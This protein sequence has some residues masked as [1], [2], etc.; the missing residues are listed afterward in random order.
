MANLLKFY[1]GASAPSTL[2]TGTIWFDTTEDVIKVYN[3]TEWETYGTK[4]V[5][6]EAVVARVK[7]LEDNMSN[8]VAK[9]TTIAGV[10]LQDSIT[11]EELQSALGLQDAAYAT[12]ASLESTMDSKDAQVKTDLIGDATEEGNT[13]GKLEDRIEGLVAD[14]KTYSI[15]KV[16]EGLVEN[17]KEAYKLVDEDGTQVGET[18]NIYKDSSLISVDLVD[19]DAEG[20]A[21]QYIKYVYVLANGE[22][23]TQYVDVS[24]LLVEAEFKD[25]LQVSAAGEVSV[26]V[27]AASE[28]YLTVGTDG[29]KLSGVTQAIT[30]AV[31]AEA[32]IARAAEQAN[33]DAIATVASD[34][35]AEV[36]RATA[37]EAAIAADLATLDAEVQ[38]HEIVTAS[39]LIDLNARIA[40]VEDGV[41]EINEVIKNLDFGVTSV[42]ASTSSAHVTVAPTT[43]ASGE[44]SLTVDVASVDATEG[45]ATGL[46]TDAY[47]REQ[48]AASALCWMEGSF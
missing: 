19:A 36:T 8:Y 22:E 17:V 16:T 28:S 2:L 32:A 24:R 35:A 25:G 46:A 31:A 42:T 14:A 3:G 30:D 4:P 40:G 47:V 15:A 29:I 1:R 33:A 37:A 23:S 21:G 45:G 6:L 27:D 10:D 39:A 38:E 34:L 20:N 41:V 43:A 7:T 18:I 26:K 13:L 9:T 48:V 44:V 11:A 5:D 12:V